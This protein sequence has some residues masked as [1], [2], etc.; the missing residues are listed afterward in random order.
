MSWHVRADSDW[1]TSAPTDPDKVMAARV[2][3]RFHSKQ[4]RTIARWSL[5]GGPTVYLKRHYRES[6]W[7]TLLAR[8]TRRPR[9]SSAWQEYE[10]LRWATANELPVPRAVAVGA[11]WK[12]LAGFLAVEEL[13]GQLALH[14]LIPRAAAQLS[15][16]AFAQWKRGLT[17]ELA[18]ITRRLHHLRCFHKDLYFCHFFSPEKFATIADVHW[19]GRVS[20]IDLHR[21]RRHRFAAPWWK[22]KDL[23]QLLYSSDVP[24]VTPRDRLRFWR[25]YAGR[26]RRRGLGP[27]IRRLVVVRWR[28]YQGHN[29]ARRQAA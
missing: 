19:T 7:R 22:L 24:G 23:S 14:E 12:A 5:P 26:G 13:A 6:W 3:D 27:W 8:L 20:M 16:G 21:L 10:N 1:L 9:W 2:Q 29:A 11:R 17:V 28:N 15:P 4:G 18:R 25:L